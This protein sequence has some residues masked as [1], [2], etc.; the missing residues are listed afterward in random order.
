MSLCIN[1][2]RITQIKPKHQNRKT[3][4]LQGRYSIEKQAKETKHK[5]WRYK[6][7]TTSMDH[8]VPVGL[9]FQH[10][11]NEEKSLVM[12]QCVKHHCSANELHHN[13]LHRTH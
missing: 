13:F 8:Q 9:C 6:R 2:G 5:H 12:L 4:M 3:G 7:A 11:Y 10:A 1:T